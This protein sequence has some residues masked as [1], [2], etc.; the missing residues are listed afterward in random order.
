MIKNLAL[1]IIVIILLECCGDKSFK[2]ITGRYYL[3][4]LD[5]GGATT[6]SYKLNTGNYI[7]IIPEK[8]L[9]VGFDNTYIIVK[10]QPSSTGA[11][12]VYFVLPITNIDTLHPQAGLIGPLSE[13][14]FIAKKRQLNISETFKFSI[15]E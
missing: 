10:Q 14:D 7:G 11:K 15:K 12:V 9:A 6:V 13:N 2:Q 8:V 5:G 3:V 4:N 1:L